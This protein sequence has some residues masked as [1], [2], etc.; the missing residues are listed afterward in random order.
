VKERNAMQRSM[1]RASPLRLIAV[2]A[3]LAGM[4]AAGAASAQTAPAPAP[5]AS[6]PAA[7]QA[8]TDLGRLFYTPQQRAELD[9]RR[10]S[11]VPAQEDAAP[12]VR[13]VLVTVNGYVGR[14][15]GK[16]TT[17]INGVPQYDTVKSADPSRVSIESAEGR[18][19]VKVGSTL[20]TNR[21]DVRDVIGDGSIRVTPAPAQR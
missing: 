21:G 20:D 3:C 13:E 5:A 11:N 16:T 18:T 14:S 15:S 8:S 1:H 7:A 17:W 19:T 9:K 4:A 10:V 6:A 12:A 2:A